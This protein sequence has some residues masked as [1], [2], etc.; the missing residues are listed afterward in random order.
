MTSQVE[1]L[2]SGQEKEVKVGVSLP[3]L[4]ADGPRSMIRLERNVIHR[5]KSPVGTFQYETCETCPPRTSNLSD[6]LNRSLGVVSVLNLCPTRLRVSTR[7]DLTEGW[8]SLK[9]VGL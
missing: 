4:L 5:I 1:T 2:G 7:I 3:S 9:W 6:E 8:V